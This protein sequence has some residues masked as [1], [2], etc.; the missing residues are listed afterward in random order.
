MNRSDLFER[1]HP[2]WDWECFRAGMWE[3]R[4]SD[5]GKIILAE[6]VLSTPELCR[7]YMTRSVDKWKN[8]AEHNLSKYWINRRPWLGWAA[9]C[10][11]VGATEEETREAWNMRMSEKEKDQANAIADE[12]IELW[13]R[14]NA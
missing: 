1:W 14:K 13:T 11:S 10:F 2:Y 8:S 12:V 9:C 7:L 5:E 6:K 3:S 4:S